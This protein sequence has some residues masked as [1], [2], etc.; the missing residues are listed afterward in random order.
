MEERERARQT[1]RVKGGV[2][3]PWRQGSRN[4]DLC[5]LVGHYYYCSPYTALQ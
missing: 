4:R 1:R 2:Q 5:L 3:M